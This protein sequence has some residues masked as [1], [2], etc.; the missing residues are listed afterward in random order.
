MITLFPRLS[1]ASARARPMPDPPP[2]MK[3]VFPVRFIVA[4]ICDVNVSWHSQLIVRWRWWVGGVIGITAWPRGVDGLPIH[5][6]KR[7]TRG[8]PLHEVG[9]CDV[10]APK[11]NQVRQT[12]CDKPISPLA[13]HIHIGDQCS[14][15]DMTEMPE[16][17]I[18]GQ[19]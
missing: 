8:E 7:G 15:V 18:V 1:S 2:V 16:H 14:F 19:V 4:P 6:G 5:F 10:R 3:I 17:A 9:I 12:F 11:H 13:I